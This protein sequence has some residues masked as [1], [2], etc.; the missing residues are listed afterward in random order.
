MMKYSRIELP[1]VLLLLVVVMQTVHSQGTTPHIKNV[2]LGRCY[3]YQILSEQNKLDILKTDV[4]CTQ[5][6]N[7]FHAAFAFKDSCN[8][9]EDDYKEFFSLLYLPK[10][11]PNVCTSDCL[12]Y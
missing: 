6:W 9:T 1:L 5:L 12:I 4:N 11:I 10:R 2:F 3:Q 8:V 7:A